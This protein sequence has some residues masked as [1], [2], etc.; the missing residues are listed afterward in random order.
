MG[1]MLMTTVDDD[2]R[3]RPI[4]RKDRRLRRYRHMKVRTVELSE[5][6]PTTKERKLSPRQLAQL[7]RDEEI[8][9][10]MDEA[11]AL[12]ASQAVVIDLKEGQKL[13]TFRA[14]VDR[15]MKATPR[16]LNWGVRGQSIVISKGALPGRRGTRS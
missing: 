15:V 8:R 6:Q 10:A 14:A 13:P 11:A 16:D 12:P 5:L 2:G 9:S 7:E 1:G 3:C 4:Q